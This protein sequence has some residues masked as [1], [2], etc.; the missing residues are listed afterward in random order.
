MT[1]PSDCADCPTPED[2]KSKND[3]QVL[4][5]IRHRGSDTPRTDREEYTITERDIGFKA[6]SPS[7]ARILE[8]EIVEREQWHR[9]WQIFEAE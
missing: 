1:Y 8:R 9:A 5:K 7:L 2:C 3:C 4:R 6:V